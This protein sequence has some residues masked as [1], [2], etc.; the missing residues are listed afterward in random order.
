MCID[1]AGLPSNRVDILASNSVCIVQHE[2]T[3]SHTSHRNAGAVNQYTVCFPPPP[4]P[5]MHCFR[6]GPT[7]TY[8]LTTELNLTQALG[9]IVGALENIVELRCIYVVACAKGH[10]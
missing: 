1:T 10:Y 3:F 9:T 2:L 7:A 5:P 4:P 8:I 6:M